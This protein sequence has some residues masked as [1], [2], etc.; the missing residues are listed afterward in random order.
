M[1]LRTKAVI[2]SGEQGTQVHGVGR[3]GAPVVSATIGNNLFCGSDRDWNMS[4]TS[5]ESAMSELTLRDCGGV[6]LECITHDNGSTQSNRDS[7][8][9]RVHT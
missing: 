3:V 8:F 6:M 9:T 1:Q 2:F 7:N 4:Q 5:Q